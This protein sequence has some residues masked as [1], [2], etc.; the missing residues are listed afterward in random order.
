[1]YTRFTYLFTLAIL[2]AIAGCGTNNVPFGGTV[3]FS[4]DGTPLEVGT[5]AFTNGVQQARGDLGPGGKFDLGFVK[6]SDGLPKGT[7]TVYI[8]GAVKQEE[9][10]AANARP[11]EKF[12][13]ETRLIAPKYNSPDTSGLT[14]T[15][16]G[17]TRTFDI[18]VDRAT[19]KDA[20]P[21]DR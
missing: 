7:Y 19:G 12:W 16:D 21:Q 18:K 5:V 6:V 11:G 2:T 13:T 15:V 10:V 1:M 3:T 14:V 8:T 20:L 4:D 9:R 17:T